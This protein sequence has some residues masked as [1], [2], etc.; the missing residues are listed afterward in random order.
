MTLLNFIGK[1]LEL[2]IARKLSELTEN[3]NLFS[4][5]QIKVRKGRLTET[6]F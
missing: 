3:N 1:I 6:I 2:V 5:I 4:E